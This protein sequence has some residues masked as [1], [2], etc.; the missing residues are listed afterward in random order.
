MA[1][2]LVSAVCILTLAAHARADEKLAGVAC[3]SV[4]LNYP[5]PQGVAFY[6]EVSV[7]KSARGTY[8]CVCGFNKG[9]FGIQEKGDGKKVVIFSVWEPGK[10]NNPNIVEEDRR[11]KCLFQGEGV[12]VKRFGGEGTGGQSF[13]DYDWKDETIYR[14]LVTATA[15][16]DRTAYAGYFH[17]P[18]TKQWKHLVTFSTLAE[19]KKLGGYYSFVEDFKRNRVSTGEIRRATFGNGWV[20]PLSGSWEPLAKARFTGDGNP[21]MNVD[22]GPA[23]NR[24]YL[25]TGGA[26]T[27]I[28]VKLKETM[29]RTGPAGSPPDDLPVRP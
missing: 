1:Q 9:Y 23:G 10:Q 7:Q 17:L 13:L 4:H 2:W 14:F 25:A 26:T 8:F 18:E 29:E 11:T 22:A 6:N 12:Q 21:A 24:F 5:A 27:N 19:G 28:G 3:R 15:D 16:G 20:K